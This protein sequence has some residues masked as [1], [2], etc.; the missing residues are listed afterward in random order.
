MHTNQS[1]LIEVK[2]LKAPR[3]RPGFAG[4]GY[5]WRQK[6]NFAKRRNGDVA[7]VD[8]RLRC[9]PLKD[10]SERGLSRGI[11]QPEVECHGK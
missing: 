9:R 6:P 3:F 1:A 2:W 11:F 7:V 4:Q 8:S 10:L 5:N